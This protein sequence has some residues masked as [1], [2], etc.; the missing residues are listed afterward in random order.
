MEI[1]KSLIET[2]NK[3]SVCFKENVL[4]RSQGEGGQD[5]Q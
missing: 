5:Y 2:L 4:Q 1:A 3:I